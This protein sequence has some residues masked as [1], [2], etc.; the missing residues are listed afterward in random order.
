MLVAAL[1]M[2]HT[3]FAIDA[4]PDRESLIAAIWQHIGVSMILLPVCMILGVLR[5]IS[6]SKHTKK[7]LHHSAEKLA[8]L[9]LFSLFLSGFLTVWARG[10]AIKVFDWFSLPS[11]V[12]RMQTLY[13]LLEHSH[14]VLS[15][16][17]ILSVVIW[18]AIWIVTKTKDKLK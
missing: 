8:I 13:A 17:S 15:Q 3:G 18:L 9:I 7:Q 5:L 4:Q 12:E 11:P 1:W 14:G 6:L 10:S 16:L 2:F